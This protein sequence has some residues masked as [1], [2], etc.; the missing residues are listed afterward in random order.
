MMK[1][2]PCLLLLLAL[3]ACAH[4]VSPFRFSGRLVRT[5]AAGGTHEVPDTHAIVSFQND[6]DQPCAVRQ[7]TIRWGN[8][9][10]LAGSRLCTASHVTVAAHASAEATC[11]IAS[12][13][14]LGGA[15]GLDPQNARVEPIILEC[16]AR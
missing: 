7:Y 6:G 12:S 10:P 3:T 9:G 13:T 15:P 2:I 4:A 11:T 5:E 8:A 14:Q 1:R 16:P